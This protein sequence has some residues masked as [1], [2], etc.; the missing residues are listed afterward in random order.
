MKWTGEYWADIEKAADLAT[1]R[2]SFLPGTRITSDNFD[3]ALEILKQPRDAPESAVAAVFPE[4]RPGGING[5]SW[6]VTLPN[7]YEK[8]V[9]VLSNINPEFFAYLRENLDVVTPR[10]INERYNQWTGDFKSMWFRHPTVNSLGG[11]SVNWGKDD[12]FEVIVEQAEKSVQD[13]IAKF[14]FERLESELYDPANALRTVPKLAVN[15]A[16]N[17]VDRIWDEYQAFH[18]KKVGQTHES[19]KWERFDRSLRAFKEQY[20]DGIDR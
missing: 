5:W 8:D 3:E 19:E 16:L 1:G 13:S 7:G 18:E 12:D 9:A 17:G 10:D 6:T 11:A 15:D 20:P 2:V 14:N 4:A